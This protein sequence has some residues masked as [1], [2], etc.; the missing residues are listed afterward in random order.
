M[1]LKIAFFRFE[2]QMKL[3]FS[4]SQ[5]LHFVFKEFQF[6]F[7]FFNL[8]QDLKDLRVYFNASKKKMQEVSKSLKSFLFVSDL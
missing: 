3:Q 1:A 4:F 6:L 7:F 2:G 5:L 8:Q